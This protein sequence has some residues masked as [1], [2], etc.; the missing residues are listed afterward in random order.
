MGEYARIAEGRKP[1]FI[2][3]AKGRVGG[4]KRPIEQMDSASIVAS[5][6]ILAKNGYSVS[7]AIREAIQRF[8]TISC[9]YVK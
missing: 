9:L 7:E 5:V 4:A 1:E 2:K 6:D 8:K 3:P